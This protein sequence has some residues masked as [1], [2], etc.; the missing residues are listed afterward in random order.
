MRLFLLFA[1]L[2][3]ENTS[4][5]QVPVHL[6]DSGGLKNDRKIS[7]SLLQENKSNIDDEVN[8]LKSDSRSNLASLEVHADS[9]ARASYINSGKSKLIDTK[10]YIRSIPK[11]TY[12]GIKNELP[13]GKDLFRFTMQLRSENFIT[14]AQNPMIRS[15]LAYSRLYMSPTFTVMGLPFTSNLFFTTESNNTYKNN[16]FAFRLDVNAMKRMAEERM[17][18]E[19]DE[20]RKLDRMRQID[21][22]KNALESKRYQQ[23]MD[24]LKNEIPDYKNIDNVLMQETERQSKEYLDKQKAELEERLKNATEEEKT[25]LQSEYDRRKDSL[26]SVNRGKLN[27]SL[28]SAKAKAGEH[29]DTAKINRLLKLQSRLE[30]LESKRKEIERL[31]QID[32]AG[33]ASKITGVRNPDQ[34][35]KLAGESGKGAIGKFLAV[36]RLGI[37]LIAPTYSEFTLYVASVKG[38][39]IGVSKEKYFYDLSIGR[40]SRQFMGPFS[41]E[42]P[43][44]D[45]NVAAFRFGLGGRS[46]DHLS[47]EYM[48]AFDTKIDSLS[49]NVNNTVL[50]INFKYEFLNSLTLEGDAAQSNYRERYSGLNGMTSG[51]SGNEVFDANTHRA[52]R[53]KATQIAGKN[54]EL[55]VEARQVGAAFRSV[56]NP[57]LRRNFREVDAKLEQ[58][59]WKKKIKLQANYKEMRD[60][61]LE[62]N[63]ST[64]RLNGWGVKLQTSFEKLPNVTF[65]H[66]PYQ[67]GNNHPDSLYRT[68]NQF[69]ITMLMLTYRKRFKGFNWNTMAGMTRSAM[70]IS[71]RGPVAYRMSTLTQNFQI[72]MRHNLVV[73]YLS[74]ITAPFVDSL[75]SNSGQFSYS[76]LA[77]K[78]LSIGVVGEYTKYKNDAFRMGSGLTLGM[79]VIK[80]LSLNA[81]FRYDKINGLWNLANQDVWTG[82]MVLIW[83][84]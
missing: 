48:N 59:F 24:K 62:L 77:K 81:L 27:D 58:S 80:N 79:N 69:S 37:G 21:L 54:T 33:M 53:F 23:E 65:S 34:L 38:L 16:F 84:W 44:F 73:A 1:C 75:N 52:Y 15:E 49:P 18:K 55:Q 7:D 83:R 28:S 47:I 20:I 11:R 5:S 51:S 12:L 66:S 9:S 32:T 74:N 63:S 46:D 64:N 40:M 8:K 4:F 50:N 70:E 25:R 22:N 13:K 31:R 14:T 71:G 3:F 39:D 67:Q 76:Y 2:I 36:D 57:F 26:L 17:R 30:Q 56:G 29:L 35:R 6:N 45:R 60:N 82:R 10:S 19:V 42:K 72:G 68:N 78:G 61:L 41:A 43:M